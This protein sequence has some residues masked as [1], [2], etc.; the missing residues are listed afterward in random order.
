MTYQPGT[1]L[2]PGLIDCHV[3]LCADSGPRALEQL[4]ELERGRGRRGHRRVDAGRARR[5]CHGGPRPRRP[6][7]G[8]RGPASRRPAGPD[9]GR[10]RAADHQ[11][12]RALR[13]VGPCGRR[14]GRP[15][16]SRRR[17]GRARRRHRQ[18]DDE[19]RC[20]DARHRPLRVLSSR[21]RSCASWSRSRIGSGC[22][23]RRTPT[24]W[25]RSSRALRRAST[26]SSTA[27]AWPRA[28]GARRRTWLRRSR[29]RRSS[30][31]RRWAHSSGARLRHTS[32]R[33]WSGPA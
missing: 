17:A 28:A 21:S 3:H 15:A 5:R 30:C 16:P 7:L 24:R 11:R 32:R 20:D 29:P 1:T 26:A 12:R 14:R 31:A 13:G 9:R 2:L 18:G 4:P 22:R 8:R 19:R 6:G 23:S 27:A 33:S 25:P 10:R